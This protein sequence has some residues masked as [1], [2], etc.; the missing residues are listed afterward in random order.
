MKGWSASAVILHRAR[1]HPERIVEVHTLA[2]EVQIFA[3]ET[4]IA[5][6]P[7]L[8][9]AGSGGLRWAIARCAL[10]SST[11]RNFLEGVPQKSQAWAWRSAVYSAPRSS[12]VAPAFQLRRN[13]VRGGLRFEIGVFA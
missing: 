8:D 11:K 2:N 13:E 1:C 10:P 9:G 12:V 7:V 4:L 5:I 6:D 3:D